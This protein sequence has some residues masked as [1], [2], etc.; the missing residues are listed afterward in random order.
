MQRPATKDKTTQYGMAAPHPPERKQR[1]KINWP[2]IS[3]ALVLIGVVL[4]LAIWQITRDDGRSRC[5][6]FR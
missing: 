2:V 3:I 6:G 4:A 5:P 1:S